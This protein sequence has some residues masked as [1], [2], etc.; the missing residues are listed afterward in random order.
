LQKWEF[1][2]RIFVSLGIVTLVCLFSYATLDPAPATLVLV[3]RFLSLPET[4]MFV[5][6]CLIAALVLC[7]VSLLRMWAGSMLTP[8]RVMSFKIRTDQ[9]N[10]GGPYLLVRNP[11]YLADLSAMCV[12]ALFLPPQGLLLPLLF[13]L[14]YQSIVRYEEVSL[15]KRFGPTFDVY[16]QT[17]PRLL[18]TWRSARLMN[19]A[20]SE[21]TITAEGFRHNALF[22]LFVPGFLVALQ[23]R[24]FLFVILIGIP[25]VLD[26][27]VVHTRLG[28]KKQV[29]GG[30]SA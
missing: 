5:A 28:L 6:G 7:A 23:I 21:F 3:A 15:R 22:V 11:I 10:T 8:K 24:E 20:L 16:M 18:P 26:W 25:A 29:S 14:H 1:E 9:L 2:A 13:Y 30:T 17:T 12:F 27:A 19:R 4:G